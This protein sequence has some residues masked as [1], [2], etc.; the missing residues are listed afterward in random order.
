MLRMSGNGGWPKVPPPLFATRMT[1]AMSDI[2]RD[3][4]RA[5][6]DSFAEPQKKGGHSPREERIIAGFEEIQRFVDKHGRVPQ[7]G[8]DRDIFERLYAVRLDRAGKVEECRSLLVPLDHQGL[9]TSAKIVAG[10]SGTTIGDDELLAELVGASGA[11]SITELR[12]V[13]KST[14]K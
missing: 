8:E 10:V 6:L 4:L 9:L 12:H 2:D 11:G 7:H 13:R 1:V 14:D 5:E 3:Q